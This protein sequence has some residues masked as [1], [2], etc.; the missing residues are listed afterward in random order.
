MPGPDGRIVHAE[1]RIGDSVIMLMDEMPVADMFWGDRIGR[2]VDPFGDPQSGVAD[3]HVPPSA[4]YS[5]A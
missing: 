1:R 2:L 5:A 4:L 3:G